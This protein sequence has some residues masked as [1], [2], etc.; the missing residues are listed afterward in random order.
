MAAVAPPAPPVPPV[1]LSESPPVTVPPSDVPPSTLPPVPP[2]AVK[3]DEPKVEL[4]PAE[5][6]PEDNPELPPPP[7]P[8]TSITLMYLTVVAVGVYVPDPLV[9]TCL[10]GA[11]RDDAI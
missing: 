1:I 2:L 3:K 7:P 11:V 6:A 5:P 4:V 10:V 9:K 8:P